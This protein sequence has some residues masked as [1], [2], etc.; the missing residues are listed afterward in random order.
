MNE[1]LQYLGP[2]C[3]RDQTLVSCL[4]PSSSFLC[5]ALDVAP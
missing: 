3:S 4:H 5:T 2:T 1:L